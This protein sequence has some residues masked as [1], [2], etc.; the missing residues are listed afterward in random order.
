[1]SKEI[2][3]NSND[4]DGETP[5]NDKDDRINVGEPAIP[6]KNSISSYVLVN[7]DIKVSKIKCDSILY[8]NLAE[9]ILS[10][11]QS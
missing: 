6:N 8:S 1:M 9:Y 4:F 10:S 5:L 11:I 2:L 3:L 7:E